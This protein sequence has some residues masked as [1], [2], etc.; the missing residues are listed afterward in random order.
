MPR[1][2]GRQDLGELLE[3]G[4]GVGVVAIGELR[5][6]AGGEEE[7]HGLVEGQPERRQERAF[8]DPPA[9]ALA[10]QR[11]PDLALERLQVPVDGPARHSDEA[12]DGVDRGA[13][14]VRGEEADHPIEPSQPVVL[15]GFELVLGRRHRETTRAAG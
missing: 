8:D 15:G 10:P 2:H 3:R 7:G 14:G 4:P 5:H 13:F 1:H 9:A 11:D 6:Q 12:R